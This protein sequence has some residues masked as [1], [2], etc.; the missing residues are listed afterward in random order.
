MERLTVGLERTVDRASTWLAQLAAASALLLTAVVTYSVVMRFV[1]N[2]SQNWADELASYC[3]LWMVFFGLTYTLNAGAHI[4]IDFFTNMLTPRLQHRLEVAVWAIGAV[5][6]AL[7][8]LGC[9]SAVENFIRRDTYSTEGLDIPLVWPALPML[10]GSGLFAIAMA[11][12]LLRLI[13]LGPIAEPA[14]SPSPY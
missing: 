11:A 10:L 1:F 13:V 5:F 4:R 7:L 8:F 12:R 9:L 6:A 14:K 3:L 2:S